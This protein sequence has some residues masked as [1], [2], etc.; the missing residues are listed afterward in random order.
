MSQRMEVR[1][2]R[3]LDGAH[4][5]WKRALSCLKRTWEFEDY[6]LRVRVQKDVPDNARY[7]ARVLG[8]NL[9]GLG[10]SEAEALLELRSAY[11]MRKKALSAD[12]KAIPRPG[13][14]VPIQF[15]SEDR[16]GGYPEILQDFIERVLGLPWAF[17]SDES[18]L[19]DFGTGTDITELQGRVREVYGVDVS[20][21]ASG[22]IAEIVERIARLKGA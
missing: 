6:P 3:L 20:D 18:S 15:A 9:D 13:T 21:V 12:G 16:V 8:W 1:M 4:M 2:R 19:W 14:N 11:E 22:N 7:W 5:L 17:I 10:G